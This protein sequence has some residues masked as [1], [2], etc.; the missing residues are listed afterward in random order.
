MMGVCCIVSIETGFG[1]CKYQVRLV[2]IKP[3]FGV[4]GQGSVIL[5]LTMLLVDDLFRCYEYCTLIFFV[6]K[7]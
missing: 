7:M 5:N 2:V 3:E 6:G 1:G 4:A